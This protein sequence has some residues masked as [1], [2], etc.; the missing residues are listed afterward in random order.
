MKSVITFNCDHFAEPREAINLSLNAVARPG[1]II[2]IETPTFY[3]TLLSIQRLGMKVEIA[4]SPRYG[5]DLDSLRNALDALDAAACIVMPHFQNPS[6]LSSPP[7]SV[8]C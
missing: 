3:A 7:P 5:I 6:T 4:T 8:S 2:A 1:D